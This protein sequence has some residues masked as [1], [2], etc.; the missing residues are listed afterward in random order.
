MT[1]KLDLKINSRISFDSNGFRVERVAHVTGVSGNQEAQ[2]YRAIVD[3]GLPRHG[4]PHPTVPGVRLQSLTAEPVSGDRYRVTMVYVD[5]SETPSSGSENSTVRASANTTLEETK[6]DTDG[7]RLETRWLLNTRWFTAEVERPRVIYDF[8]YTAPRFP[9]R[10]IDTYLGHVNSKRWNGYAKKAVLCTGVNVDQQGE[11]YRV[12]M[13]FQIN[14]DTWLYRASVNA[15]GL[16]AHPTNPDPQLNLVTG[17]RP[18][19]L[20]PSADFTPLGFKL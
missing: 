16:T 2:L 15:E 7:N 14:E 12:R 6:T 18:F 17:I 4:D 13:T 1:A 9:K 20:Y 10:V 8:T 3:S 19:D 11:D 5:D